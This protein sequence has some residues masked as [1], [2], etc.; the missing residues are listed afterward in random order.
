MN[1]FCLESFW[2]CW[3]LE[4]SATHTA[5]KFYMNPF[6]RHIHYDKSVSSAKRGID[7]DTVDNEFH[8]ILKSYGVMVCRHPNE[9]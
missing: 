4:L 5:T 2:N 9:I 8:K 7:A 1:W 6:I 3:L